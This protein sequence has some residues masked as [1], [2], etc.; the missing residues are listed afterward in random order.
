VTGIQTGNGGQMVAKRASRVPLI[1][2]LR[3]WGHR[4]ATEGQ[5]SRHP[6]ESGGSET[7]FEARYNLQPKT[8]YHDEVINCTISLCSLGSKRM[9]NNAVS[10]LQLINSKTRSDVV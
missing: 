9:N 8:E 5:L 2:I 7:P 4:P 1:V 6:P 10:A 3:K